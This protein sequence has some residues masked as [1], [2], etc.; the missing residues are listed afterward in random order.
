MERWPVPTKPVP[1]RAWASI[2]QD[3]VDEAVQAPLSNPVTTHAV[4][5]RTGNVQFNP[6]WGLLLSLLWVR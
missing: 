1:D 4:S 6:Q 2:D 5:E 3:L